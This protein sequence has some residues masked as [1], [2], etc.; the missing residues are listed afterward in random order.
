[1]LG[2]DGDPVNARP[3]QATLPFEHPSVVIVTVS[4]TVIVWPFFTGESPVR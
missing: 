2:D 3:C 4:V 1:M